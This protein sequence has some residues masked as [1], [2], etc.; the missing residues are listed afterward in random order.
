[1]DFLTLAVLVLFAAML[2]GFAVSAFFQRVED[3]Q[4]ESDGG[5]EEAME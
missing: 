1:M 2:L 4:M 5:Y 3:T